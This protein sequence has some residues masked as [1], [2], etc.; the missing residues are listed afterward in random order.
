MSDL[1]NVYE[2]MVEVSNFPNR[3]FETIWGITL[4]LLYLGLFDNDSSVLV[5]YV[6]AMYD[7]FAEHIRKRLQG[8]SWLR[9]L[10]RSDFSLQ[11]KQGEVL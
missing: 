1:T 8:S 3:H 10:G 7:R 11:T 6:I 9:N 2:K 5:L 4:I